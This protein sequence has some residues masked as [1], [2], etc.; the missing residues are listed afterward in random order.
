[1]KSLF[2]CSEKKLNS[3]VGEFYD[4]ILE[5]E[6]QPTT[7][8]VPPVAVKVKELIRGL[9]KMD[10]NDPERQGEPRVDIYLDAASPFNAMLQDFQTVMEKEEKIRIG[11]PYL[12]ERRTTVSDPDAQQALKK[13]EGRNV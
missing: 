2:V 11:L 10:V 8:S 4:E 12:K 5:V 1:M 3:H 7:T 6:H 9:W 13:L